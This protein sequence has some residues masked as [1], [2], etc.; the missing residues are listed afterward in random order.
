L[1]IQEVSA[2]KSVRAGQ[3]PSGRRRGVMDHIQVVGGVVRENRSAE[4]LAKAVASIRSFA[5]EIARSLL[6][7]RGKSRLCDEAKRKIE[8]EFDLHHRFC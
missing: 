3:R 7:D 2:T 5:G 4:M 8:V 6:D 1:Q